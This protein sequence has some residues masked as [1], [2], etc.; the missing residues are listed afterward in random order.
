M[1]VI[2]LCQIFNFSSK[3]KKYLLVEGK[4]VDKNV[5]QQHQLYIPKDGNS[6][7]SLYPESC[8]VDEIGSWN[9]VYCGVN[10][11]HYCALV[12]KKNWK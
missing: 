10:G 2:L 12:T 5:Q 6:F 4:E 8:V 7:T 3:N 9:N 1:W 11:K